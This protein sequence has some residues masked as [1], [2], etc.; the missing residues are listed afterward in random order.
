MKLSHK[1]QKTASKPKKHLL[2]DK[3]FWARVLALFL[4]ILMVLGAAAVL[5]PFLG[6]KTYGT[7]YTFTEDGDLSVCIGLMYADGVTVGFETRADHGFTIGYVENTGDNKN[8]FT[9]LW[10]TDHPLVS[11]TCDYNLAKNNMTYSLTDSASATVIG[12]WHVQIPATA[13]TVAAILSDYA[14]FFS[15][16]DLHAFPASIDGEWVV[17]V[18]QLTDEASAGGLREVMAAAGIGCTIAGPSSTA[19]TV[20]DPET[21]QILFEYDGGAAR[22]LGLF[23]QQKAGQDTAYLITPARN[24]YAGVFK[25]TRYRTGTIDGVA[26]TNVLK[27]EEYIEGVV[28]YEIGNSWPA[29]VMRAFAI[30]ARSYAISMMGRH[31]TFDLCN[32]TCCQVY[33]G[34]NRVNEAVH[35]AVSA[36]KGLILLY[37]GKIARTVYSSS[38]GGTTVS[39]ADAWGGS[40]GYE[41]LS[42]VVTP[43]EKYEECANGTWTAEYSPYELYQRLYAQGYTNLTSSIRSVVIDQLAENSSYVYQ[44]TV[45][46]NKGNQATIKRSDKIRTVF[47]LKSANFSVGLA[48]EKVTIVDYTLKD[49]DVFMKT[50]SSSTPPSLVTIGGIHALS[51]NEEG[52]TVVDLGESIFAVNGD[53]EI[54][55]FTDLTKAAV[56]TEN[57]MINTDLTELDLSKFT[58]VD[59]EGEA[60]ADNELPDMKQAL[61][62]VIR[63]ERTVIAD[64][65]PGNFVFIGRGWGHGVGMS[66]YG[67]MYLAK[68]GYDA[69]T[70]LTTY[71]TGTTITPL[72]E[73]L[74]P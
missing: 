32:S 5:I 57:G 68:L 35:D 16:N 61:T 47:G 25:Y 33:K 9:Q 52:D 15:Q 22:S 6:M 73:F 10:V 42:A 18:G 17:R 36:T 28:P 62:N 60:A 30:A 26:V 66:Q 70:I 71:Y 56:L 63:T 7:G 21:D 51:A 44:I 20:L 46:D 2:R 4:C 37:N 59:N 53:G 58:Y 38:A 29:E 72:S 12:G 67:A 1:N 27:L 64:G 23:P 48:G 69:E 14:L 34:R 39:S 8:Q 3:T 55:I 74:K 43:W 11:V 41:Y 49:G 13:E 24:A 50:E 65:T 54:E 40:V 19:V 31:A 45:T